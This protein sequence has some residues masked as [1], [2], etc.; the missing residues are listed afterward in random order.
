[1]FVVFLGIYAVVQRGSSN[2]DRSQADQRRWLALIALAAAVP[3][4]IWVLSR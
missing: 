3:A 2:S 4:V 1:M